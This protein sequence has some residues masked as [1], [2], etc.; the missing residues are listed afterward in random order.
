MDLRNPAHHTLLW[1]AYIDDYCEM[2]KMPKVKNSRFLERMDWKGEKRYQNT[3]FMHGW[4]P[5]LKQ[6]LGELTIEPG[7]FLIKTCLRG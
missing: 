1:I 3:R 5:T 2:Y 4:H 7:R 6:I